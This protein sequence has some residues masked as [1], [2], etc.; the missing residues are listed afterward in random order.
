MPKHLDLDKI[1]ADNPHVDPKE[2]EKAQSALKDLHRTGIVKRSTYGLETPE[3]KKNVRLSTDENR[4]ASQP[5]IR[6]LP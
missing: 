3:S 1:I 2:L 4:P 6:R 5:V